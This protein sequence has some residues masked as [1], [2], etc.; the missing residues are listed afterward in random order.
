M[1]AHA[2]DQVALQGCLDHRGQLGAIL[3]VHQL[4]IRVDAG[5]K[6]RAHRALV[7]PGARI[8][9]HQ[10]RALGAHLVLQVAQAGEQT[11]GL[12]GAIGVDQLVELACRHPADQF[13]ALREPLRHGTADGRGHHGG[14]NQACR[15]LA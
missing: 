4:V 10:G 13:V 11:A 12:V 9:S 15:Q 7:A 1:H 8:R 5:R 6:R 14:A 3:D 2:V